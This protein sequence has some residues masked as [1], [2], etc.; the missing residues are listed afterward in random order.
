MADS[1]GFIGL[2]RPAN[3]WGPGAYRGTFQ[4]I[5]DS[6]DVLKGSGEMALQ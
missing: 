5:R 4:L 1:L 2:K 3:G 6:Q